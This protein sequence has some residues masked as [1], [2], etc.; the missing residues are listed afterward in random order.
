MMDKKKPEI[1]PN[2]CSRYLLS[3]CD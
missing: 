1:P 3:N 2:C